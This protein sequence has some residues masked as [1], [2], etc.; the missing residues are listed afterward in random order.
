MSFGGSVPASLSWSL[1]PLDGMTALMRSSGMLLFAA[2]GNDGFVDVDREDCFITCWESAWHFPCENTGVTCVG[3]L[4]HNS[5]NRAGYSNYGARDVD[6]FGPGTLWTSPDPG[7]TMP[8]V[9]NGTSE[10]SPFVAGVAALV[11]AANPRLTANQV[12][13]ILFRTANTSSDSNVR[14]SVNAYRA[15]LE[16]IGGNE[17]PRLRVLSPSDGG[18]Y[19]YGFL[20]NPPYL[21]AEA[22]DREDG[23]PTVVWQSSINGQLGTGTFPSLGRELSPGRHVI[24]VTATDRAGLVVTRTLNITLHNPPPRVSIREPRPGTNVIEGNALVFR[25]DTFDP[26][27]IGFKVPESGIA[28]SSSLSGAMGTGSRLPLVLLRGS[29]RVTVTATDAAGQSASAAIGV[30]IDPPPV[31]YNPPPV[32]SIEDIRNVTEFPTGFDGSGRAYTDFELRAFAC[33]PEITPCQEVTNDARF[34]WFTNRTDLQAPFLMGGR[35]GRV[36][37]YGD[38]FTRHQITVY[39]SDIGFG[40]LE[41]TATMEA[42]IPDFGPQ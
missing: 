25:A 14:R 24:T 39:V 16:A 12:E 3:A 22:T 38:R 15:V 27:G 40:A 35:A 33:D 29:H 8:R 20:S 36:R 5:R 30:V 41:G 21:H 17:P 13:D 32:V 18:F 4:A 19:S 28:W 9:S 11:L 2:S 37:L 23:V 10:A 6:I 31:N 42:Q 26:D 1:L 34:A 7:T